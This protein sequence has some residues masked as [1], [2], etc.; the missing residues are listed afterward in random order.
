MSL[1]VGAAL[2]IAGV[3][4]TI[5]VRGDRLNGRIFSREMSGFIEGVYAEHGVSILKGK[6]VAEFVGVRGVVG[7][8]LE[9][10]EIIDVR[11]QPSLS[12]GHPP[13]STSLFP[14]LIIL[15]LYSDVTSSRDSPRSARRLFA[16]FHCS[17][18]LP[19]PRVPML[20]P[21]PPNF[22]KPTRPLSAILWLLGS[23]PPQTLHC[24]RGP[25]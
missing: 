20:P 22:P 11:P 12:S 25:G 23:V 2:Q 13:F 10:G 18:S 1:Q 7:V 16:S 6:T 24:W 8:R 4:T 5:V 9:G 15:N 14:F 19:K 21:P 17:W 3:S